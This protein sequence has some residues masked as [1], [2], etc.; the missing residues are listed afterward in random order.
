[1]ADFLGQCDVLSV[2]V[3]LSDATRHLISK[4]E[5]SQM[6]K[7]SRLVNTARGPVVDEEALV[8]VL[9]SGHLSGA[10]LDV[11]EQE[12]KV[13]PWLLGADNV[14]LQPHTGVRRLAC[15]Q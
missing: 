7:G 8:E 11:F 6:K 3:P 10:G 4:K 14:L 9:K 1:M 5:L 2:H 12:P 15:A 13:H